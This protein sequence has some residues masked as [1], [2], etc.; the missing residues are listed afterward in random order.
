MMRSA[1]P[2]SHTHEII[3]CLHPPTLTPSFLL[4]PPSLP[5]RSRSDR[6]FMR[7]GAGRVGPP[8]RESR[9]PGTGPAGGPRRPTQPTPMNPGPGRPRTGRG[10]DPPNRPTPARNR[11]IAPNPPGANTPPQPKE[12]SRGAGRPGPTTPKGLARTTA[13]ASARSPAPGDPRRRL[14][15][16]V[17]GPEKRD[18]GRHWPLRRDERPGRRIGRPGV[19]L[20]DR[21]DTGRVGGDPGRGT[22]CVRARRIGPVVLIARAV[23]AS[24]DWAIAEVRS[25]NADNSTIAPQAIHRPSSPW[26][27]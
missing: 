19:R 1:P 11:P 22:S 24:G 14:P 8:G 25:A 9:R 3:V 6:R 27:R 2:H 13:D 15:A 4:P 17:T 20:R 12:P 18:G 10:L 5:F 21:R 16:F 26:P 7:S 23:I